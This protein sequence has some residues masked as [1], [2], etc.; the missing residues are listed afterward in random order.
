MSVLETLLQDTPVGWRVTEV[1]VGL[2]WV[3]VQVRYT[4]GS[5]RAGV[6]SVQVNWSDPV[7]YPVGHYQLDKDAAQLL[8]LLRSTDI[9][10][11]AVGL[12]IFNALHQPDKS[13]LVTADAVDWLADRCEGRAIAIVG[14][15]PFIEDE[16]RPVADHVYVFEREPAPG[17]FGA[18][19]MAAVLPRADIVAITSSTLVNHTLDDI[20][21]VTDR[22][23]VVLLGPSTPLTARLF[24]CGVDALFGVRVA[25]VRAVQDSVRDGVSFRKMQGLQRVSLFRQADQLPAR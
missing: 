11:S 3:L 24:D 10:K 2:H 14:R 9:T 19:D 18:H 22:Q 5:Q 23:I 8:F 25:D 20:L 16:L 15:F 17:E 4:D 21:A 1:D 7:A 12:A 13:A 6:A